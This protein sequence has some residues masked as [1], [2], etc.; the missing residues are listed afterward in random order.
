MFAGGPPESAPAFAHAINATTIAVMIAS[1]NL[2][3]PAARTTG[4]SLPAVNRLPPIRKP[5]PQRGPQRYHPI[6][7]IS[8]AAPGARSNAHGRTRVELDEGGRFALP[9]GPRACEDCCVEAQRPHRSLT[10]RP[11]RLVLA[12]A[13]CLALSAIAACGRA[14]TSHTNTTVA[15]LL[16]MASATDRQ[17]GY[18]FAMTFAIDGAGQH[19]SFTANGA[20][21]A[22]TRQG[23]LV[24]TIAGHRLV[25]VFKRPYLYLRV[26][27]PTAATAGKPWVRVDLTVESP[28]L[29]Q[30]SQTPSDPAATLAYLRHMGHVTVV[31]PA[32]LGGR[33][34][35]RYRGL[36]DLDRVN[37]AAPPASRAAYRQ[38]T[39]L[40]KRLTG[41]TS[42][43]LDVWVDSQGLVRQLSFHIPFCT[44]A[45]RFSVSTTLQIKRYGAQPL[46]RIPPPAQFT[47]VTNRLRAQRAAA[48]RA[49]C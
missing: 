33:P 42:F 45:G 21:D 32:T 7:P 46:V 1:A 30:G 12:A 23:T 25:G 49:A 47:D 29:G 17:P 20:F 18:V 26:P 22:H 2:G 5:P 15:S 9:A 28:A 27:H 10:P 34:T 37:S 8:S 36:V 3:L 43:P 16:P 35:T 14:T 4:P 19:L 6:T 38:Q 24:E 13:V 44:R 11:R 48:A 40:F 31:G 41:K 39:Q